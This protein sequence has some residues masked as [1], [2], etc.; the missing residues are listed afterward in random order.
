MQE[1]WKLSAVDLNKGYRERRWSVPDV[2]M[3]HVQ[4]S[5]EINRLTNAFCETRFDEALNTAKVL[6]FE[7]ENLIH[8]QQEIPLFFGIPFTCK[9]SIAVQGLK[10]TGGS[11]YYQDYISNE[12]A[13]VVQRLL[14]HKAILLGTT[15]VPELG[16]WFETKNKI[17]GLTKNPYDLKRT[18]GG[19]SGGEGAIVGGGGAP[20]GIGS[21]IGG[22]LRM[23][24]GFCGVYAHKPSRRV[25]SLA[26]HFPFHHSDFKEH[27]YGQRYPYTTIGPLVRSAKD[28]RNVFRRFQG[29][30]QIDSEIQTVV[31]SEVLNKKSLKDFHVY[32]IEDPD[33]AGIFDSDKEV[34]ESVLKVVDYL[35]AEGCAVQSLPKDYFKK[36]I[37]LWF[38]ALG[39]V[40]QKSF[41]EKLFFGKNPSLFFEFLKL[42]IGQ[43]PHTFPNLVF[44]LIEKIGQRKSPEDKEKLFQELLK[45]K[46]DFH[47][48]I[49]GNAVFI[50]PNHPRAAP[51]H[52]TPMI[53]S[54]DFIHTGIFNALENPVTTVPVGLNQGGLPLSVQ[55]VSELY[56]DEI[57]ISFAEILEEKF[58]GWVPPRL[59]KSSP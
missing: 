14:N 18:P 22:S 47:S 51:L 40:V 57:S 15:N 58:G 9:E 29:P 43:S 3:S 4:K 24:A 25:I 28:L 17:H 5:I 27:L 8:N 10:R 45:F 46:A 31:P 2:I 56:H 38:S 32:F 41:Y 19:S 21:D 37:A 39:S 53:R 33:I 42:F 36:A 55:I 12:T 1:L 59:D 30:D 11:I 16:F 6:Q 23:P 34:V 35:K 20:I 44:C 48:K 50:F 13:T 49:K 26:G 54:F 52:Y 7:L